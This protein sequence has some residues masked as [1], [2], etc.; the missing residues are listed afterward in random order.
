[1]SLDASVKLVAVLSAHTTIISTHG[2]THH[3]HDRLV[4]LERIL[5]TA[6]VGAQPTPKASAS[7]SNRQQLC[8][9]IS[10][11]VFLF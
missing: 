6:S 4:H 9:V 10:T 8:L 7:T 1:M 2:T 5:V 3:I 11:C